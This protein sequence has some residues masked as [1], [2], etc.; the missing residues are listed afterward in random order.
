M[1]TVTKH[2]TNRD[3]IQA[4]LDGEYI[5]DKDN[6]YRDN[7][8]YYRMDEK[9]VI[10][11]SK[12]RPITLDFGYPRTWVIVPKELTFKQACSK[13]GLYKRV[14]NRGDD[15]FL[16]I[17]LVSSDTGFL[18]LSCGGCPQVSIDPTRF[19][20]KARYVKV[21]EG[22]ILPSPPPPP[23]RIIKEGV[24]TSTQVL[25]PPVSSTALG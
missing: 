17:M 7:G 19:S 1:A 18:S 22:K 8:Y 5:I 9:G 10:Y 25:F 24:G 23:F 4:F 2:L 16:Q 13:A 21:N 11:N 12:D 20:D 6:I 15:T 3:A 14:D